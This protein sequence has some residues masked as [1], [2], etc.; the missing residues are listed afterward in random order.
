MKDLFKKA[1]DAY[2]EMLILHIDTKTMDAEFHEMSARFY[3][4]LFNT[5]HTIG[6]KYVDLGNKIDKWT[7]QEK[8]K[9]A[10]KLIAEVKVAVEKE[11]KK[12][13]TSLGTKDLLGTLANDLE[14]IQGT[15][16]SFL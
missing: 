1:M 7:L 5:A 16:K 14:N 13:T 2:V 15:A 9:L 12:K 4:T 3:E 8:I 11:E 6:E 10:N